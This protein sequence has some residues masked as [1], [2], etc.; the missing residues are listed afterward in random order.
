MAWWIMQ[1][2][3]L[4][5]N[6]TFMS[7]NFLH[8]SYMY[9]YYYKKSVSA[10]G[11]SGCCGQRSMVI[12]AC[13]VGF[14]QSITQHPHFLTPILCL[15]YTHIHVHVHVRCYGQFTGHF[16]LRQIRHSEPA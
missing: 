6:S 5:E 8:V 12:L 15:L 10:E 3:L 13:T 1:A 4:A 2:E 9:V 16:L 7:H 11:I 14:K